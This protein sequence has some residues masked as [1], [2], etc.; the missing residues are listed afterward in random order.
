MT[1]RDTITVLLLEDDSEDYRIFAKNI[2]SQRRQFVV[3]WAETLHDALQKLRRTRFDVV[4]IDLCVPDSQGLDTVVQIKANC[5][6]TPIIV[7]TGMD[8]DSVE[9]DILAAG[10]QDYLVKGELGGR[11]VVRSILHAVQRQ[12]SVNEVQS[13]V[14]KLEQSQLLLHQQA[15]LLQKKNQRLNS[16]AQELIDNVSHDFRTP[17]TVIKDFVSIIGN[18]M[19]GPINDEQRMM[20]NKV[21]IRADDLNVMVDDLLDFSKLES[22]LL[23]V[24]RRNVQVSTM[25]AHAESMLQQ[26]AMAKG[27]EFIVECEPD[28]P[29]VYCDADKVGRVITNLAINA[30]KFTDAPGR[31]RIWAE[32]DPAR[33]QVVMGVSDNGPGIDRQSLETI[34]ER[35]RQL[36]SHVKS[37]IKGFGLGLNIAQLLCRQNLGELNVQSQVAKGST[38]SFSIPIASSTE[39][40]R[41]WLKFQPEGRESLTTIA[42]TVANDTAT[43]PADEFDH[44]QNFLLRRQDLLLRVARTQWLLVLSIPPTESDRWLKTANEEF[45]RVNRNRPLE[46]LPT[47]RAETRCEWPAHE[48]HENILHQFDEILREVDVAPALCLETQG[49]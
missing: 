3:D 19:V 10:A 21:N 39:I 32:S 12:E 46:P 49:A 34:F 6:G 48:T 35:F 41:R 14:Q 25:I 43:A 37:P 28:L 4:L 33:H 31:V 23:G 15:E 47:Y 30:I 18:G 24:W 16:T 20:L 17:L 27:I 38:F 9:R 44:F 1:L 11:L 22:G 5:A 40:L 26:R 7:L 42:V 8:D 45:A 2:R 36:E 29:E 13:L